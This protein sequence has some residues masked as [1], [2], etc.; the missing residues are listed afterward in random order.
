LIITIDGPAASGKGTVAK[1][2]ANRLGFAYLDTG[3]MYRAVALAALSRGVS[4]DDA[5]ALT[6]L[7][8][9]I[10]IEMP[11]ERV[12][13]NGE[14]V[15][16]AIRTPEVSQGASRVAAISAV[17]AFLIPQQRRIADG[18]NIVCE[19]RDQGTVVFPDAPVKFYI[20]ADVR[21][22]AERRYRELIV[23]GAATTLER[24]TAELIERDRRDSERAD[25]PLR[26]P[27][28]AIVV[29]T[30]RLTPNEVLDRLEREIRTWL[31]AR[32]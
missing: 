28:D 5:T 30:S 11:Q 29:D 9:S 2:I 14:D 7:L 12:L 31:P 4:C 32:T 26:T 6:A 16:E 1:G 8:P 25:G 27:P 3:A 17:R 15:T 10:H 21:V 18:R 22:R 13:L 19:G 24:E 23:R 20:T